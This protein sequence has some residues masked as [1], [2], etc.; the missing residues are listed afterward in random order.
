MTACKWVNIQKR[1][2]CARFKALNTLCGWWTHDF[3]VSTSLN[4][5][6][7]PT[8]MFVSYASDA[9][10]TA[11]YEPFIILQNKQLASDLVK[12]CSR[13][14]KVWLEP[15]HAP[16]G[17]R[18]CDCEQEQFGVSRPRARAG[19]L[20]RDIYLRIRALGNFSRTKLTD[21]LMRLDG[22]WATRGY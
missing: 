15:L 16:C 2:A 14:S 10:V 21:G 9:E 19:S 17:R 4:D 5:G 6:I 13:K 12:R 22:V 20:G 8:P 1:E 7:S 18:H 11:D 3:S